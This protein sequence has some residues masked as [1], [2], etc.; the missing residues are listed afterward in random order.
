MSAYKATIGLEIHAELKTKSKMFCSCTNDPEVSQPNIYVC[1]ICMGHPGTLPVVNKAA[2]QKVL[3][4][5]VA[6]GSKLADFTEFDRKNYFYPDIPKGYQISQYKYPLVTGGK[7]AGVDLTRIHLEEDTARSSHEK[8]GKSLVDFNRAGV[9]LMELVT[10]PVI[11]SAEEA[12]K[13]A[14]ELQILLQYMD[15]SD[16]NMEKGQMRVEVNISISDTETFGTKV[17]VKN[18]NSFKAA[19][20]AIEYE[21][22]RQSA[23]LDAGEKVK[24]ETRGWDENK[25]ITF[26]QRS[27]ENSDDYRYFPDP[28]IPKFK[29]SEVPGLSKEEIL[30]TIP[31][32]PSQKRERYAQKYGLKA[33]DIENYV[34]NREIGAF[35]EEAVSFLLGEIGQIGQISPV[36]N[37]T[38]SPMSPIAAEAANPTGQ[39]SPIGPISEAEAK[40]S[41]KMLSNYMVSDIT[42]ITKASNLPFPE[43]FGHLTSSDIAMVVKMIRA[44]DLSSRGAKEVIKILHEKGGSPKEIAET[45]GFIQKSDPEELKK[46]I[47][48]I[49]DAN[50][51]VVADYKSGKESVFQFF[52]GQAMKATKGAGNP[53]IIKDITLQLLK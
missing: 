14:Q 12:M 16:A 28:D 39:I 45:G 51:D 17:E 3:A 1:P 6:L 42:G 47:Q 8:P 11:H 5:G 52:I 4:V 48:G 50:P 34:F 13:F 40:E 15:I 2:V 27:K 53:E 10:E 32:I 37:A 31:E 43:A 44:G 18:I 26:S 36:A 46:V 29:L 33:E 23:L 20:K 30:K 35:F 22:A 24:Q 38:V 41:V 49:M 21:F 25:Q 9:P 19:G 7:L